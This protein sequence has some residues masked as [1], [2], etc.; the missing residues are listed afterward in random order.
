[1]LTVFKK[2][3]TKTDKKKRHNTK[4]KTEDNNK[5]KKIEV[6]LTHNKDKTNRQTD[7]LLSKF[8]NVWGQPLV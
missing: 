1:M 7:R 3:T 6:L 4:D 5:K 8:I 2:M